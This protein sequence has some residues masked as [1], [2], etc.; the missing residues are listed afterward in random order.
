M[1]DNGVGG[2]IKLLK[3]FLRIMADPDEGYGMEFPV[4]LTKFTVPHEERDPVYLTQEELAT[5]E[6]CD[7]E[8]ELAKE[9]ESKYTVQHLDQTRDLFVFVCYSGLRISDLQR[10]G[11]QHNIEGNVIRLRSHK[12]GKPVMVPILPP[13][14]TILEKYSYQLPRFT[15]REYNRRIKIAC[16]LAGIDAPIEQQ[17]RKD[18]QKIYTKV[19]KWQEISSHNAI[20]TF[21]THAMERGVPP[22]QIAQVTGKT[23]KVL[24]DRYIGKSSE[25]RTIK[26][27]YKAYGFDMT[28]N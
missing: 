10:V 2:I 26:A 14:R 9:P 28:V 20:Y 3:A 1:G 17:T 18:G 22:N 4:N 5:L 25:E 6:K 21:C 13:N 11:K 12:T 8:K 15:E 7:F 24:L 16:R 27:M 23:V 19:P